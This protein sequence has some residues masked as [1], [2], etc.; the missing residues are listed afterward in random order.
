MTVTQLA[1]A[2]CLG[3]LLVW[4]CWSLD[5]LFFELSESGLPPFKL[6]MDRQSNLKQNNP[7]NTAGISMPALILSW[8]SAS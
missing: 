2:V 5:K 3:F 8:N 1:S 6:N 7:L 4:N